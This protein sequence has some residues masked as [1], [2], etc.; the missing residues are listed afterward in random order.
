L[1]LRDPDPRTSN[2]GDTKMIDRFRAPLRILL[3]LAISGT[4]ARSQSMKAGGDL[5][6]RIKPV[7]MAFD[8]GTDVELE[9]SLK[10]VS[11]H[12][13]LATREASLHDLIYLEVVDEAG[14]QVPWQGK[15]IS[16][17][18]PASFWIIL[19]PGQSTAFR[20]V[21][22]SSANGYDLKKPGTYRVRAE[23][24]ISPKKYFGPVA[25]GAVIP[26]KPVRSNWV[27]VVI[28]GKKPLA[29][30]PPHH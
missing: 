21:I 20:A 4:F 30:A 18:Y 1:W 17:A 10:N 7:Q 15:I 26:E 3:V 23:L 11:H 13:V 24:S 2:Y 9:F 19:Q 27:T 6:F 5:L 22:S 29:A 8:Q 25:G 14:K 12:Q 28:T 16:R